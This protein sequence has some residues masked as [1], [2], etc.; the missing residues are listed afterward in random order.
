MSTPRD[1]WRSQVGFIL[2]AAGSAIGLGNIWRFSYLTYENGGGA[3]LV[4]YLIALFL[5]GIPLMIVEMGLGHF[6]RASAPVAMGR[7]S[8]RF[9]WVGWW[10]VLLTLLGIEIY[11][12][13]IIAWCLD[14]T[15]LS[16][17]LAWGNDPNAYFFKDF[18]GLSE[19]PFDIGLPNPVILLTLALV[20]GINWWIV[21]RGVAH[22]IEQ[23][24][25]IFIPI[26]IATTAI[27]VFW[28][29]NLPGAMV[30]V[31]AYLSPDWS[32][33]AQGKVWIDAFTQIFFTL[34]I[35]FGIMMAYASYLPRQAPVVRDALIVSI[36]NCG[37]S[38]FAGF[39]VFSTLGFMAQA[40]G[41]GIDEVVAQSIG[42]AFV[43]YPEAISHMP[44][45]P[46][47]FG[48]LFFA[49]LTIAGLSSS[50]SLVEAFV[51]ALGDRY[52]LDRKMT[53]DRVSLLGFAGGIV[54]TTG[55]GLFW[56]DIVDHFL[57][58]Y[59]LTMIALFEV[60]ATGWI[61]KSQRLEEH[62][63]NAAPFRMRKVY[64]RFMRIVISLALLGGWLGLTAAGD[65]LG[66]ML[67][68]LL[69]LLALASIWV[70]HSWFDFSVRI[71]IPVILVILL[72]GA[73][74]QE[75][76]PIFQDG[77]KWYGGYN[78]A[79]VFLLGGGWLL[80]TLTAAIAVDRHRPHPHHDQCPA[81]E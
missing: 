32:K 31:H 21:R 60:L 48:F 77:G 33:L 22:G 56:L 16:L 50:V 4:P 78:G 18:L 71:I 57:T 24:N 80:G 27:L 52:G 44:F 23:A 42:L 3:F 1:Q 28:S 34:S 73:L 81:P 29:L 20:W 6:M 40:K 36:L 35:G 15:F 5:V 19:G 72:D 26:L 63:E 25:K 54:F 68:R 8:P 58:Q 14:F 51:A 79:A 74:T 59:G 2:A 49:S 12:C 67:G 53:V 66:A 9:Q 38:L 11:Y 70:A 65:S 45:L 37:F 47:L 76:A 61:L 39:A 17:G 64:A 13:V 43:A 30:G 10:A 55:A 62:L 69:L 75:F 46:G 41:V 7:I